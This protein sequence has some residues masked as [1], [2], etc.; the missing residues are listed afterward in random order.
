MPMRAGVCKLLP[1]LLRH[2]SNVAQRQD[3]APRAPRQHTHFKRCAPMAEDEGPSRPKRRR[4]ATRNTVPS[5]VHYLGY[6]EEDETP[7]AI[8]KKFEELEK[9][10]ALLSSDDSKEQRSLAAEAQACGA[11]I[12]QVISAGRTAQV[13]AAAGA[14]N[15][16]QRDTRE[17]EAGGAE[18]AQ[19]GEGAG[20]VQAG[21][22]EDQLMEVFKQTSIFNVRSA[23]A[24]NEA[25]LGADGHA[26]ETDGCAPRP[27][28]THCAL[29]KRSARLWLDVPRARAV[30]WLA[31]QPG[32]LWCEHLL[33]SGS[34]ATQACQVAGAVKAPAQHRRANRTEASAGAAAGSGRR[35]G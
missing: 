33:E 16:A 25:L 28:R 10:R 19:P 13:M 21:L 4:A 22:T 12:A 27:A 9:V 31:Y 34:D 20:L 11:L 1:S 5:A 26:G 17:A 7:E 24:G 15:E 3:R 14:A 2:S 18:A 32:S 6:V 23:M 29:R 35:A 30:L 8:M